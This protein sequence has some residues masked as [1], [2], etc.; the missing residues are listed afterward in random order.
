MRDF[1][2]LK[3]ANSAEGGMAKLFK[4]FLYSALICCWAGFCLA[5]TAPDGNEP[6]DSIA[7]ATPLIVDEPTTH[8]FHK[9]GDWDIHIFQML[10]DHEYE[11][12]VY[13]VQPNADIVM[14]IGRHNWDLIEW[15]NENRYGEGESYTTK[16]V[17]TN[18]FYVQIHNFDPNVYGDQ[19]GYKIELKLISGKNGSGPGKVIWSGLY[20]D[21]RQNYLLLLWPQSTL[22]GL[23]KYILERSMDFSGGYQRINSNINPSTVL[24]ED[25]KNLRPNSTY[26]YQVKAYKEPGYTYDHTGIFRG[27]TIL[28]TPTPTPTPK[29][30]VVRIIDYDCP[31]NQGW[32]RPEDNN[33]DGTYIAA[34]DG[35][36]Y[37]ATRRVDGCLISSTHY[38]TPR[39]TN[40][41]CW[42]RWRNL[43]TD[44][45]Y[46]PNNVYRAKYTIRSS[47]AEKGKVPSTRMLMQC[48]DSVDEASPAN[49]EPNLA[50]A[51]GLHLSKGVQED[52]AP[53]I[54]TIEPA[55]FN[56]YFGPPNLTSNTDITN[57]T[58][59][60]EYIAFSAE[61]EGTN[62]LEQVIVE[63]F[64]T[65]PKNTPLRTFNSD[66]GFGAWEP[67]TNFGSTPFGPA[68][69]TSDANGLTITTPAATATLIN[70]A[71]W[72][73]VEPAKC[74]DSFEPSRLYR[75]VYTLSS[76][77]ATGAASV[78]KIRLVNSNYVGSWGSEI[79][80]DPSVWKSQM[81][82]D[83][84][85]YSVWFETMPALYANSDFNKITYQFDVSDGSSDQ[86]GDTTLNEVSL[87]SYPIP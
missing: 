59:I 55:T 8:T 45:P 64:Q 4:I 74:P 37:I 3:I 11:L 17:S 77:P 5:D 23:S 12:E 82:G 31:G 71:L 66:S 44:V 79:E 72:R 43:S 51:G 69:C 50:V 86:A 33:P 21:T 47:Q 57:V 49:L 48:G 56:I 42:G 9:K 32:K 85:E 58:L 18:F 10:K 39:N 81:P 65:P 61:E 54:N 73:L 24:Y 2:I 40:A 60:Y 15:I 67:V 76:T 28:S 13:D 34:A 63:R 22:P 6:D 78:G 14:R 20:E 75:A 84:T 30:K 26:Y 46:V 53:F 68:T 35:A 7:Q 41:G 19:T 87:Y 38:P 27:T 70:Y 36:F 29:E 25:G 83:R 52:P 16:S 80:I 1:C 62:Y